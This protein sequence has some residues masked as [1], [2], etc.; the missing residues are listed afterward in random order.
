MHDYCPA[1]G[2]LRSLSETAPRACKDCGQVFRVE[3]IFEP[4]ISELMKLI[5]ERGSIFA[6][7][8]L[9]DYYG[10]GLKATKAVVDALDD[11]MKE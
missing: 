11:M 6:I 10:K 4:R 5:E 2:C 7:K 1:C 3:Q 8:A 9:R